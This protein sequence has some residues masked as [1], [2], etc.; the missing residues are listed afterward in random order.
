MQ[1]ISNVQNV[2]VYLLLFF[3]RQLIVKVRWIRINDKTLQVL[4]SDV[5]VS[6]NIDEMTFG[7]SFD[8]CH[9]RK[10]DDVKVSMIIDAM[11]WQFRCMS[12]QKGR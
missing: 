6:M 9:D 7:D 3:E 2:T 4:T 10:D 11:K 12:S 8:A 1:K 5:K